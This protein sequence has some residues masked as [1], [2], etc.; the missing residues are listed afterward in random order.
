MKKNKKKILLLDKI[1]RSGLEKLRKK[2][3]IHSKLNLKRKELLKIIKNYHI[4]VLKSTIQV[5]K[6]LIDNANKLE[7]VARA[8][9]G[10]DN[11]DLKYLKNKKIKLVNTPKP[12]KFSVAEFTIMLVLISIKKFS[13]SLEMISKLDFRRNLLIGRNLS[14]IQIGVVGYGNIGKLVASR[15]KYLGAKVSI[16]DP[17]IK[18][19]F[20]FD[21][22]IK[23][24]DVVTFHIPLNNQT[25]HLIN[26]KKIK[27]MKDGV[28]L[29]NTSRAEIFHPEFYKEAKKKFTFYTDLI[30]PEP[31]Y[32]QK[33]DQRFKK[34]P[35]LK[36][37]NI[38]F[39]PHIASMTHETQS[40]I[41]L[42]IAHGIIRKVQC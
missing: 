36:N 35:W 32:H 27:Q 2:F 41:S 30:Y 38:I 6:R 21:Y 24:S 28:I 11:I 4:I 33:K 20:D 23:K 5:D 25:K 22:L 7:L 14:N 34:H 37:K 3:V 29:I 10:L 39:T 9:T 19:T 31:N 15:F 12:S 26:S 13:K 40:E 8:G 18:N 1:H 16:Y 42:D 17:K